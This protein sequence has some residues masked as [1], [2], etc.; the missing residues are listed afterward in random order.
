MWSLGPASPANVPVVNLLP[1]CHDLHILEA[2]NPFIHEEFSYGTL[3]ITLLAEEG[4]K[5][6]PGEIAQTD[7]TLTEFPPEVSPHQNFLNFMIR[8]HF[9]TQCD[10][11]DK[12]ALSPLPG[13]CPYKGAPG[14]KTGVI[15]KLTEQQ[16][17]FR[18]FLGVE[19]F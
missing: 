3:K 13:Y 1:F 9:P 8:N 5:L 11:P 7:S 16:L 17:S 19:K 12:G 15:E 6:E 10:L 2:K 14:N 4:R 18:D